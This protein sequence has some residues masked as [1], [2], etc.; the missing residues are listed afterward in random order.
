MKTKLN[1]Q[2]NLDRNVNCVRAR[3]PGRGIY[4]ASPSSC[5]EVLPW[6]GPKVHP[7]RP[8]YE[9][10]PA[11]SPLTPTPLPRERGTR[12]AASGLIPR[13]QGLKTRL[14]G[15]WPSHPRVLL[16]TLLLTLTCL[17]PCLAAFPEPDNIAY[18]RVWLGTNL[19]TAQQTNVIVEVRHRDDT[20]VLSSYR[21]GQTPA[22]GNLYAVAI[23][24]GPVRSLP[25]VAAPTN[26]A[27]LDI[28]VTDGVA[29]RVRTN[30]IVGGPT[31]AAR[32]YVQQMD[33]GVGSLT[34][35][36]AWLAMY[37]IDPS[38][39]DGDADRDG[40]SNYQEY[41]AGTNP[42]NRSSLFALR[43]ARTNANTRVSF[44]AVRAT[45]TG[46]EGLTRHYALERLTD[47]RTVTWASVA[48]Y[49]DIIGADQE[50]VYNPATATGPSYFRGKVWLGDALTLPEQ[51]RLLANLNAG[52]LQVSFT[53]LG[54]D[55]QGRN[56]YYTLEQATNAVSGF[57]T[58]VP[59]CSNVLGTGQTVLQA[60]PVNG[61]KRGF[62]RGR[63][64][65]R[66]P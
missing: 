40:L 10:P 47:L 49:S 31:L 38:A 55:A 25:G 29:E 16:A 39:G 6:K 15:S 41:L 56:A 3:R 58:A 27:V 33:L 12:S 7:T 8:L 52:Q 22:L 36:A 13:S 32:G 34:G 30:F 37:N 11:N 48:G 54:P 14:L 63:L 44:D 57:W 19:V 5:R 51:F 50:V 26:G 28:V 24:L 61:T 23:H 62:Y 1:P 59:G 45:G 17:P 60:F 65:L 43:I 46:Y 20:N 35:F 64:D 21:M 18:G 2:T 9:P 42:T 4:A 66:N 53:A